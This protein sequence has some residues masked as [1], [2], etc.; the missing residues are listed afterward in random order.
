MFGLKTQI[1]WKKRRQFLCLL[2]LSRLLEQEVVMAQESSL[3][4]EELKQMAVCLCNPLDLE[5]R[6][7]P[8]AGAQNE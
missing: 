4:A 2:R 6:L 5:I 1:L 3:R 7:S 8:G